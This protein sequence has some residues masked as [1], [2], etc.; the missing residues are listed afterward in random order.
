VTGNDDVIVEN[1]VIM[2][3][4]LKEISDLTTKFNKLKLF[5]NRTRTTE[6]INSTFNDPI[7]ILQTFENMTREEDLFQFL[8]N[9]GVKKNKVIDIGSLTGVT[10]FFRNVSTFLQTRNE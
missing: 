1:D 9:V 5:T 8:T 6:K 2:D 7:M 10:N 3:K 4:N